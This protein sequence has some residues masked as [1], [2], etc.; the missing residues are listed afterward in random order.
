VCWGWSARSTLNSLPGDPRPIR[1]DRVPVR[2]A[3]HGTRDPTGRRPRPSSRC[4]LAR[5]PSR[6]APDRSGLL[7][8]LYRAFKLHPPAAT[9]LPPPGL[10]RG[11]AERPAGFRP[12]PVLTEDLP[13]LHGL[14]EDRAP[15]ARVRITPRAPP[16][17]RRWHPPNGV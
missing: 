16:A 6:E 7:N 4:R 5:P 2:R 8:A 11:R 13:P 9:R 10:Q 3:P 15:F 12:G 1:P 17:A 14:G